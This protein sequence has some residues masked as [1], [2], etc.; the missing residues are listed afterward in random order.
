MH[1]AGTVTV[2]DPIY[3][4]IMLS[5]LD[6]LIFIMD[7]VILTAIDF[8]LAISESADSNICL[9]H[10]VLYDHTPFRP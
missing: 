8:N 9:A 10:I 6:I 3:L 5:L 2:A 1:F 4:S 7:V